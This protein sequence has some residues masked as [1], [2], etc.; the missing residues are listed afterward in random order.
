MDNNR[1]LKAEQDVY[2][3][4]KLE[5]CLLGQ[6]AI[7][8]LKLVQ[9]VGG[10]SDKS[11]TLLQVFPKLFQ[12][13]GKLNGAYTIQLK[14]DACP[15][16]LTTPHCVTIPLIKSVKELSRME[17]L[18]IIACINEPTDWCSG[19]VMYLKRTTRFVSV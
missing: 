7:E 5:K 19:M 6:P 14:E 11:L 8:A 17:K 9:R 4:D 13:L 16:A 18:G 3:V 2:V 1:N 10:V 12:G 15:Y